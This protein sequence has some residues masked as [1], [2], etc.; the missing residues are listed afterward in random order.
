MTR[1]YAL[2]RLLEHGGLTRGELATITGWSDNA[3]RSAIARLCD[4][5][6]IVRVVRDRRAVYEVAR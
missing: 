4:K 6:E 5:G 2:K 1:N 3:V